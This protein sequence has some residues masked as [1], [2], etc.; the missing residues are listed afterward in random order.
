MEEQNLTLDLNQKQLNES[1]LLMFGTIIQDILSAMQGGTTMNVNVK[2]SQ[3][4]VQSFIKSLAGEKNYIEAAKKYGLTD[5]KTF[6][7]KAKA[8]VAAKNFTRQTG[9]PFPFK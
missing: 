8:E 3:P 9:I 4:Q 5:P 7:D 6:Q 1:W 2:G